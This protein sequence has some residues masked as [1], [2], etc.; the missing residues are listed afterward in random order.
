ML[1]C[2][3]CEAP[4]DA[5]TLCIDMQE[6]G[7]VKE[8]TEQNG[9]KRMFDF[10]SEDVKKDVSLG[11]NGEISRTRCTYRRIKKPASRIATP[12]QGSTLK[13]LPL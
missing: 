4:H 5:P 6:Q 8:K 1:S 3:T 11:E 2:R 12:N 9:R 10:A 7:G 13:W